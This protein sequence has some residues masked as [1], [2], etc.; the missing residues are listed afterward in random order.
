MDLQLFFIFAI[1][2]IPIGVGDISGHLTIF[3]FSDNSNT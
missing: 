1:E 2:P 3:F